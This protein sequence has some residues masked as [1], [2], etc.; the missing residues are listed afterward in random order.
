MT[1]RKE[2]NMKRAYLYVVILL[3]M[4][5]TS[6][7]QGPFAV[8]AIISDDSSLRVSFSVPDKHY[9]YADK[10]VVQVNG[11][12]VKASKAPK[13]KKKFDQ[14]SEEE[15]AVY[16]ADA[17]LEYPLDESGKYRV[18]VYYQGCNDALCFLP[19]EKEFMLGGATI[20]PD[21][22]VKSTVGEQ[23]ASLIEGFKVAG[24]ASGYLKED[25]FLEFVDASLTG[26]GVTSDS[27][28]GKGLALTLLLILLGGLALNL[29]PCVLPMIPINIAIIGAGVGSGS[30]SRGFLL[31]GVYGLGIALVYGVLGL[32][33]VLT[34]ARFGT[35]NSSPWFNTGIAVLFAA[36]S[37]SMF[38]MF[39]LDFSSLQGKIKAGGQGS[40]G[41]FVVSFFLGGVAALLAGACVAPVVISVLLLAAD[42]HQRNNHIGLL[43]PFILGL[44]MALPWPFAGA[45]MSFL[46]KPG[47]WMEKIKYGFGVV[48]LLGA[49]YYG[50][51]AATLFQDRMESRRF[52]VVE[53][54]EQSIKDG[55]HTNL[56]SALAVSRL[57]GKPVFIDFWASW[58]KNC[59]KM[60]KTT[61]K[62][63][64]VKTRLD[65][66]VKVKY[67]AENM[68]DP[69]TRT[70]LDAFDI[71]GL[72]TY[73]VL[74]PHTDSE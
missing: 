52:A 8:D 33:V 67:R 12:P 41:S 3:A 2:V 5:C 36:L 56:E 23:S 49:G 51:L 74:L 73:V 34:G 64:A 14:F 44:G 11:Q 18:N 1:K 42:L 55:W 27:L 54:Q 47:K 21:S 60:E 10:I 22:T 66:F 58:C 35:L 29:T 17:V 28:G 62:S 13:S 31:G 70:V 48:I 4:C 65:D 63:D 45:G 69:E 50:L 72:P 20:S 46:P 53:A 61:F 25:A 9:L 59:L 39:N 43:L 7:A 15:V 32:V 38:G 71:V 19:S 57:N 26:A 40:S 68:R 37:L 6:W 16:L 24:S 30:K